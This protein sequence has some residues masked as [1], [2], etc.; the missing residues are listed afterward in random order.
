MRSVERHDRLCAQERRP[1]RPSDHQQRQPSV[2]ARPGPARR[3]AQ[4][5]GPPAERHKRPGHSLREAGRPHARGPALGEGRSRPARRPGPPEDNPRG[6]HRRGAGTRRRRTSSWRASQRVAGRRRRR[7]GTAR[8]RCTAAGSATAVADGEGSSGTCSRSGPPWTPKQG[9]RRRWRAP[10]Q[11]AARSALPDVRLAE[12]YLSQLGVQRLLAGRAGTASQLDTFVD[13]GATA[14]LAAS[15]RAEDNG[16]EVNMVSELNPVLEQKSPTVFASLPQ[17]EPGLADE[18]GSNALAYVGVGDLGPALSKALETAGA[19]AQGL[20]GSLRSLGQS[21]QQQAG[22]NP[23]RD[24]LP[25]LGG[26]AALVAQPTG[27]VPYVSLIVDGVDEK[28]AG[29]VLASL[30][31]PILRAAGTGGPQVP[32]FKSHGHR[33]RHCSLRSAL[34]QRQPLLRPVRRQAGHLHTAGGDR[35]GSGRRQQPGGHGRL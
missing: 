18:A 23:F 20:A 16:V 32:T 2:A 3:A 30:Q 17:F 5:H 4:L 7:S 24:L 28:K 19:S 34:V 33:R 15:A 13:Y 1:L 9:S 27:G 8:S 11:D 14:G 22:V 35:S 12:V 25:A 29:D 21:L 26:Q 6:L 31:Q 10:T